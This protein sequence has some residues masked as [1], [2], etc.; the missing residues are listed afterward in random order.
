MEIKFYGP[1]FFRNLT[2]TSESLLSLAMKYKHTTGKWILFV[3]WTKADHVWQLLFGG[4]L[5]GKFLDELGVLFI[6]VHGR[7]DPESNPHN[8]GE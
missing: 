2:V 6:L 4:L 1:K 8:W 5:D 3:P 7:S